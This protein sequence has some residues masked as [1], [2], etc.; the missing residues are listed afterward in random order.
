MAMEQILREKRKALGLTQE[1]IATYLGVTT[2]AVNK[3]EKGTTCP[4]LALLPALARLLKTDPNTLLSFEDSLSEGEVAL[5]L[6]EVSEQIRSKDFTQGFKVAMEKIKEYPRCA[7]LIDSVAMML[8]G[9]LMMSNL[10][11]AENENFRIQITALYK[12]VAQ[13]D[14]LALA[15]GA[16]YMLASK[17]LQQGD[18]KKAQEML[19][20]MPDAN[21]PDKRTLQADLLVN[22]GKTSEAA[23]L[24]ERMTLTKLQEIL[25]MLTKLIP[26]LVIEGKVEIAEELAKASQTQ[27]EAFGLWQYSAYLAPMQLAVSKRD[28]NE[29]IKLIS[30]MLDA[31][32]KPWNISSSPLYCHQ[33]HKETSKD[34]R[35]TFLS[36]LLSDLE[37]N[38]EYDF[39]HK[40]P[41]F[42]QLITVYRTKLQ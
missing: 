24:L 32:V 11:E 27:Y 20:Q 16:R 5:F 14:D 31:V 35:Q 37:S 7:K 8:D 17:F 3:W 10:S 2:P 15:N 36:P 1:Q 6:N 41:K 28:V 34:M 9:F 23:A 25:M 13:C 4:D 39:L 33:P 12:R 18:N 19:E 22:E 42:Q 29:S 40:N 26:L 30:A 38:P 21:M